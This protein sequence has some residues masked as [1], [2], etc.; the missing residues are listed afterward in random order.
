MKH[1]WVVETKTIRGWEPYDADPDWA[2][3]DCRATCR[4]YKRTL[5]R[6]FKPQKYVKEIKL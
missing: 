4:F 2:R 6:D 5:C 1:I 3:E